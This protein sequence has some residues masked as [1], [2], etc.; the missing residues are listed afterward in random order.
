MDNRKHTE[1]QDGENEGEPSAAGQWARES[2][3]GAT[4]DGS[5][6]K[7]QSSVLT[8]KGREFGCKNTCRSRRKEYTCQTCR[9][10]KSGRAKRETTLKT[11]IGE[12]CNKTFYSDQKLDEK[13]YTCRACL[14]KTSV[15]Q[16]RRCESC[17]KTKWLQ[18]TATK[19]FRCTDC[20]TDDKRLRQVASSS[21]AGLPANSPNE[22]TDVRDLG[23]S[24]DQDGWAETLW[25]EDS[26]S[27]VPQE[28][29]SEE[30]NGGNHE[31]GYTMSQAQHDEAEQTEVG[32]CPPSPS[33]WDE[34]FQRLMEGSFDEPLSVGAGESG[35]M[36]DWIQNA[37]GDVEQ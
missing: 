8:C 36:S 35:M 20:R 12:G 25:M 31:P 13:D 33:F 17:G 10:A 11:C 6:R 26:S 29:V 24:A 34:E 5:R 22:S 9:R 32:V 28:E 30:D 3:H 2:T 14:K 7:P 21:A 16:P 15:Y 18:G 19:A 37:A 1:H 23:T 27:Y 4:D